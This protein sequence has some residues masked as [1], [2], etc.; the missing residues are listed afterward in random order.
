M[1]AEC[2]SNT[3][4]TASRKFF[5]KCQRS[6]TY[7]AWEAPSVAAW[8]YAPERSRLI[9]VTGK[10]ATIA[11]VTPVSGSPLEPTFTFTSD[12][13]LMFPWPALK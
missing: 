1:T 7:S 11:I 3:R 13:T 9:G 10:V 5:S 2:R 6:A 8:A 12:G 4:S